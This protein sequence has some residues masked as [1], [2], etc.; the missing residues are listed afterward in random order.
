MPQSGTANPLISCRRRSGL[1]CAAGKNYRDQGDCLRFFARGNN[2]PGAAL[3]F[4]R[5]EDHRKSEADKVVL[6]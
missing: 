6:L 3:Y 4:G 5:F 2:D 1:S